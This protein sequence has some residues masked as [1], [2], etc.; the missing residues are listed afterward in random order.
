MAFSAPLPVAEGKLFAIGEL[1]R[2]E[3][4]RYDVFS[5]QFLPFLSGIAAQDVSFTKD[6]QW[7]TYVSYPEGALWRSRADGRERLQL[8]TRPMR[9]AMPRW[10]PDRKQIAFAGKVPDKPWQVYMVSGEGGSAQKITSTFDVGDPTWSRDGNSILYGHFFR[11]LRSFT[12]H[13]YGVWIIDLRTREVSEL[14]CAE[15]ILMSPRWSP[16][17]QFLMA[18]DINAG[19]VVYDFTSKKWR[20]I[21][22]RNGIRSIDYPNWSPDGTYIYYEKRTESGT[23]FC[24]IRT[25]DWKEEEVVSLKDV[26]RAEGEFGKWSGVTPDGSP[27]LLRDTGTQE[28]YALDWEA[29]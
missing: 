2:G 4:V 19:I 26:K 21:L 27:L 1:R 24:R 22:G 10:S 16:D 13:D 6:G 28:I 14:S 29:P 3:L 9:A 11:G 25:R 17:G 23:T 18:T 15:R 5:K 12:I 20:E 8:T 7:V